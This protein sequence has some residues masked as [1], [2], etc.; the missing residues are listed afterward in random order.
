[1]P[2]ITTALTASAAA[3]AISPAT[4]AD[5]V[6]V[7]FEGTLDS[8][9]INFLEG[10]TFPDTNFK[11]IFKD[12]PFQ[13]SFSVDNDQD[14]GTPAEG[15]SRYRSLVLPATLIIGDF[16]LSSDFNEYNALL[17]GGAALLS[18]LDNP[19]GSPFDALQVT[20]FIRTDRFTA[21]D[22]NYQLNL[23][24]RDDDGDAIDT[25]ILGSSVNEDDFVTSQRPNE[26]N[27]L[28]ARFTGTLPSP[29][30]LNES[31]GDD[32]SGDGA[33]DPGDDGGMDD[34]TD[35]DAGQPGDGT[36]PGDDGADD[37]AGNDDGDADDTD[38]TD[39]DADGI[40]DDDADDMDDMMGPGDPDDMDGMNDPD[41]M[42][43]MTGGDDTDGGLDP[44]DTDNGGPGGMIIPT[45]SALLAGLPLMLGL[46]LRRRRNA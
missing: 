20:A 11:G 46:T 24:F 12:S 40:D 3:L 41:D 22:Q 9:R 25:S 38:G 35:D 37:D 21:E 2:R 10:Q 33:D 26:F 27:T 30:T 31:P 36:D 16:D 23:R 13:L 14:F 8:V 39:D 43:D 1:M 17:N 6:D 45:P 15:I 19:S 42:D 29:E 34:G 18:I 28:G 7:N 5:I 4:R 32:G 44:G